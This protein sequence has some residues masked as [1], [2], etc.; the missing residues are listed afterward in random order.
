MGV[1]NH[2]L[3]SKMALFRY[4]KRDSAGSPAGTFLPDPKGPLSTTLGTG[5]IKAANKAV[6]DISSSNK[7]SSRGQ[8]QSFS[9]EE[10]ASIVRYALLHGNKAAIRHF[11]KTLGKEIKASS[12]ST[13][14]AKY[15]KEL[16]RLA[17]TNEVEKPVTRLP[18][19][20]RGRPLLLGEKLD[21]DVKL[22]IQ[23]LRDAGGIVTTSITM[24]AATGIIRR[25]NRNLLSENGGPISITSNWAKSLL[26]RMNFV[27]R[28]V[29]QLPKSLYLIMRN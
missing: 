24:A 18:M 16:K 17:S 28:G 10:Q 3:I 1:D 27:K 8:Y 22:F 13:W 19:K 9:P 25:S 23:G 21:G 12:L 2:A 4:F 29:V 15:E 20:K 11:S 14:K 26:Y 7:L 5:R 6:L